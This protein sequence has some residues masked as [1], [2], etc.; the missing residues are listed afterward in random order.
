MHVYIPH[1]IAVDGLTDGPREAAAVGGE[2]APCEKEGL[3]DRRG[4]PMSGLA[5]RLAPLLQVPVVGCFDG[6][7]Y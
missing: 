4:T 1:P 5:G 2:P 3:G 7:G 6:V